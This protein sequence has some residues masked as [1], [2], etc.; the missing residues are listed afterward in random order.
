[1]T[2]YSVIHHKSVVGPSVI[3]EFTLRAIF[4][5]HFNDLNRICRYAMS[6]CIYLYLYLYCPKPRKHKYLLA[7]CYVHKNL[8]VISINNFNGALWSIWPSVALG[9]YKKQ[10]CQWLHTIPSTGGSNKKTAFPQLRKSALQMFCF[11]LRGYAFTF[12]RPQQCPV[13][14]GATEHLNT[15]CKQKLLEENSMGGRSWRIFK[16]ASPSSFQRFLL[17][18]WKRLLDLAATV[19]PSTCLV[20]FQQE[21]YLQ[22]F[23]VNTDAQFIRYL[24]TYAMYVL[25][26]LIPNL[27]ET[28]GCI[29][30]EAIKMLL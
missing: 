9:W 12:V 18:P 11:F 29:W 2:N 1:M 24:T 26:T 14:F 19:M 22:Q 20:G 4:T 30:Q 10:S 3:Y 17:K 7:L 21:L 15:E 28:C 27:P 25:P 23:S 13:C 5:D 8:L 6:F 16:C